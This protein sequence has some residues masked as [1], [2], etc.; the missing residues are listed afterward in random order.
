MWYLSLHISWRTLSRNYLGNSKTWE[1][2][3]WGFT[4]AFFMSRTNGSCTRIAA[5]LVVGRERYKVSAHKFYQYPLWLDCEM[6]SQI[7]VSEHLVLHWQCWNGTLLVASPA[8]VN[9]LNLCL[10]I[11]YLLMYPRGWD[12]CHPSCHAFPIVICIPWNMSKTNTSSLPFWQVNCHTL[13][14]VTK[15]F[16][17]L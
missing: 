4:A 7:Q 5:E 12:A 15:K 8:F 2:T 10:F 14:K 16:K 9:Q 13:R 6:I 3:L 1:Y 11:Y 17:Y